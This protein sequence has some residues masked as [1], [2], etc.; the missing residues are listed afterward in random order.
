[1]IDARTCARRRVAD[2]RRIAILATRRDSADALDDAADD[3]TAQ[4]VQRPHGALQVHSFAGFERA[5]S[6][7]PVRLRHHVEPEVAADDVGDGEID[8]VYRD[9]VA[10]I[11]PGKDGRASNGQRA[12][13]GCRDLANFFDDAGEHRI[14]SLCSMR[15]NRP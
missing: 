8:A 7:Q 4:P 14:G 11:G 6:G 2:D 15:H 12:R 3:V 1:M 10:D 9:A 13:Y 5:Q